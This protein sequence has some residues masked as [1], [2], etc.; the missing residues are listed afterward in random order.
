M[1][2]QNESNGRPSPPDAGVGVLA[3]LPRTRPQRS[4]PR[5]T[6]ARKATVA[7]SKPTKARA[8]EK[9]TPAKSQ[10]QISTAKAAPAPRTK[11]KP[12]SEVKAAPSTSTRKAPASATRTPLV[13]T[14]T[15]SKASRPQRK[16]PKPATRLVDESV[17]R[18]GFES[19]M[20]RASGP[21][22][23]PGGAELVATAAE[24]V[25]ELAK[26]G[27]STG[28]RLFKDLLGHLPLS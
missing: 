27:M 6:A 4:T 16:A 3:N 23:P 21:V 8:R 9:A 5:R 17:P 1:S 12:A 18:Q 13:K 19:E 24:I 15:S 11:A 28:E 25:S 20:D 26:A 2:T 14:A 10:A 22:Q 7:A